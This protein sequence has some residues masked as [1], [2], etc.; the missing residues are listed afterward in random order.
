MKIV[1]V[2]LAGLK[3]VFSII[4]SPRAQKAVETAAGLVNLALPIVVG[5]SSIN[6][7]TAK[8][9]QIVDAYNRYGIPLV[10]TYSQD[11]KSIGNALLNLATEI[12]RARLP[13]DKAG[14]A[15]N[16]LNTAVQLAYTA[17]KA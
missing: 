10:Q 3:K 7:Q 15:T 16:V 4:V 14:L 11:P 2:I 1:D 8:M 5:L 12:L 17:F 6:P 9:I 13:K